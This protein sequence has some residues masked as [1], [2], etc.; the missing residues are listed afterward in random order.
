MVQKKKTPAG[1]AALGGVLAALAVVTMSLGGLIPVMTYVTPMFCALLLETVRILC[2]EKFAWAWFGAVAILGAF[3]SPDR[4]AAALFLFVGCYPILRPKMERRKLPALWKGL[5]F[6][7]SVLIA[8]WLLLKLTGM[9]EL[10]QEFRT[11]GKWM[12]ALLLV[13]GN[14]VFFL[15]DKL[16]RMQK[17]VK[18]S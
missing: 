11:M 12:L 17:W 16:L 3:L 8:Y 1:R 18:S 6:N 10:R 9:D 2:G 13:M 15:L 5:F 14:A 4:E 7:A